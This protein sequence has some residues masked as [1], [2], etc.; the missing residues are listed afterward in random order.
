VPNNWLKL[1][2][3]IFGRNNTSDT[4]EENLRALIKAKEKGELWSR[5][6]RLAER[7]L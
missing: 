2:R 6:L 3:R 1:F 4:Y 5:N 7:P